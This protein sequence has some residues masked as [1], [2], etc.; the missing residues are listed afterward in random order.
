[1]TSAVAV[2]SWRDWLH[3]K[4]AWLDH[5]TAVGLTF[6]VKTLASSDDPE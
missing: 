1:M 4:P 3:K 5:P 6:A 2:V